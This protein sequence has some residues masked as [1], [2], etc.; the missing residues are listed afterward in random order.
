MMNTFF[1]YYL[2]WNVI[3]IVWHTFLKLRLLV[4]KLYRLIRFH[5]YAL[6]PFTLPNDANEIYES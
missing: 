4:I 6:G 3:V 2:Y 5:Y 1:L